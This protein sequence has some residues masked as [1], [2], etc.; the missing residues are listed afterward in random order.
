MPSATR[1]W[2]PVRSLGKACDFPHLWYDVIPET[3]ETGRLVVRSLVT[4]ISFTLFPI[5]T[6]GTLG[7]KCMIPGMLGIR[8]VTLFLDM[9]GRFVMHHRCGKY[10]RFPYTQGV[11][12][13]LVKCVDA[14]AFH[15]V[16]R[17]R[18]LESALSPGMMACKL[19]H[20]H[21]SYQYQVHTRFLFWMWLT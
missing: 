3:P 2:W 19:A 21:N 17:F 14:V 16:F 13:W 15:V 6:L 10:F 12:Y 8:S 7:C 1:Q 11:A 4:T 20:A 18:I 9:D 5:F